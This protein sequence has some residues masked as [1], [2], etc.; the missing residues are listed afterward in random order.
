[1]GLSILES[2][3]EILR[4]PPANGVRRSKHSKAKAQAGIET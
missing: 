2:S 4:M 1:M 3:F